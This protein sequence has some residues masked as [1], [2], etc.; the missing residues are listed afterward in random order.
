M[1]QFR[2]T[3]NSATPLRNS[4]SYRSVSDNM[5]WRAFAAS[6]MAVDVELCLCA[7]VSRVPRLQ[8]VASTTLLSLDW[9]KQLNYREMNRAMR[10]TVTSRLTV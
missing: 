6:L 9:I 7:V 1:Q 10:H 3:Y 5:R 8:K 2:C 4:H